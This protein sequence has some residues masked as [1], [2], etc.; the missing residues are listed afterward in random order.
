[1]SIKTC[2]Q[3]TAITAAGT[4]CRNRTCK[5]PLCWVHLKSQA[6]LK[7]AKSTI[8]SAG[9]GLFVTTNV[10]KG[11][12]IA[13]YSGEVVSR[14]PANTAYVLAAGKKFIDASRTT[15]SAGRYANDGRSVRRNNSRY[16]VDA[17]RTTAAI[18][19][20]KKIPAGGEVL[21]PYGRSYWK[22]PKKSN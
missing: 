16:V 11:A 22:T 12:R 5:T 3:C 18:A 14:E 1:M 7:I 4:R 20:T 2:G 9:E 15:S 21:V 13:P 6:H 8:P 17:K 19:A 10:K